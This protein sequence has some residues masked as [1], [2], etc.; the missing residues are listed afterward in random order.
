MLKLKF[1]NTSRLWELGHKHNID[2][3]P[4]KVDGKGKVAAVWI[5]RF[6][7]NCLVTA[8]IG[9][10]LPPNFATELFTSSETHLVR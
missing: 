9:R 6:A 4:R 1:T 5:S 2:S 8:R 10:L 7:L 3:K